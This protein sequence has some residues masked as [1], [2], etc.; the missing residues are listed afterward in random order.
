MRHV[1]AIPAIGL[2]AGAAVG[3]SVPNPPNLVLSIL[4]ISTGGL[5]V[6]AWR[7]DHNLAL[8]AAVAAGCFAGGLLLSADA[9]QLAWR[10]SLRIAFEELAH[11]QRAQAEAEGRHRPEDD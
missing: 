2:L 8:G 3:L 4:L 11:A 10:P 9:W 7:A 6:W 1:A 5:S